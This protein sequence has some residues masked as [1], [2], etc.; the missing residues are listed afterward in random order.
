MSRVL[1]DS[2]KGT[3]Q[4]DRQDVIAFRTDDRQFILWH[5]DMRT[6]R[7]CFGW[8]KVPQ[9]NVSTRRLDGLGPPIQGNVAE[10][11]GRQKL[12]PARIAARPRY[13]RCRERLRT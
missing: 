6:T 1:I 9:R 4:Y 2:D 5:L 3:K 11:N 13:V 12:V 10:L 7:G 8:A